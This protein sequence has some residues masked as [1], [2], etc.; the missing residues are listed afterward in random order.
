[1]RQAEQ[2]AGD[3]RRPWPEGRMLGQEGQLYLAALRAQSCAG[4]RVRGPGNRSVRGARPGLAGMV[5]RG[6]PLR[7]VWGPDG[8]IVL[9]S[10]TDSQSGSGPTSRFRGNP[11]PTR[12]LQSPQGTPFSLPVPAEGRLAALLPRAD[13]SGASGP[14]PR[15]RAQWTPWLVTHSRPD[16]RG[17]GVV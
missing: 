15:H 4:R 12:H 6:P 13:P 10:E 16:A 14:V 8:R 2:W 7:R 9:P 3:S 5:P 17:G 11:Q 1:M